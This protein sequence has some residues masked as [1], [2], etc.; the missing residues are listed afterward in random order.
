[1]WH[2]LMIFINYCHFIYLMH[3][4]DNLIFATYFT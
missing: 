3:E 4:M 2:V 1:M